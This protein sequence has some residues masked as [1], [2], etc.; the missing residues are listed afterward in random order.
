MT[1]PLQVTP[2]ERGIVRV[3]A[4]SLS[5]KEAEDLRDNATAQAALLGVPTLDTRFTE[6]FPVA[7]TAEIGL[8]G[9][10]IDGNGIDPASIA[11][12]RARLAALDGW[13]LLVYSSAFDG[14]AQ[15]LSPA[16]ALTLIG[17][18]AEPG[19]DWSDGQTLRSDS[20][21]SQGGSTRKK[22]SDAAMSG[23]V[24]M[25]ALLVITLLTILMVWI[26]A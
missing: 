16:R 2:H 23:R 4:L 5:A 6:V 3:F 18:Y 9:Y 19:T 25:A 13:V 20:A 17:T 11:P 15:T 14:T 7:D 10:L 26:A 8:A 21:K 24:A 12:D 1:D 22:P